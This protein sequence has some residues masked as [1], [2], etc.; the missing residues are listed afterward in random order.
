M[1]CGMLETACFDALLEPLVID[2]SDLVGLGAQGVD[3][4][5]YCPSHSTKSARSLGPR[6][7]NL[8]GKS[9]ID[10]SC[11]VGRDPCFWGLFVS[12]EHVSNQG[13]GMYA[14]TTSILEDD[15]REGVVLLISHGFD[16]Q[17][18]QLQK[19]D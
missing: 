2:R 4:P 11:W 3:Q 19:G 15:S 9:I 14:A 12:E 10:L 13:K 18:Q 17:R 5:T 7:G 6:F 16:I 1:N 8:S